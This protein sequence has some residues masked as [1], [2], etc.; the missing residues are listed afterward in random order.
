MSDKGETSSKQKTI[1]L[2]ILFFGG[3]TLLLIFYLI[4]KYFRMRR[5]DIEQRNIQRHNQEQMRRH[6]KKQEEPLP[7]NILTASIV[8]FSHSA[9]TD[10]PLC[11]KCLARLSP[12][13]SFHLDKG[14]RGST[15]RC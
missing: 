14:T 13:D 2:A 1:F 3:F 7:E 12:A 4:Y 11:A 15:R 10:Q 8:N 5:N 9:I 6:K